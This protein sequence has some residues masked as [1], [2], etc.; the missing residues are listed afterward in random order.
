M[1]KQKTD[2]KYWE[3]W[4]YNQ[5]GADK[6]VEYD[7]AWNRH[8]SM[9]DQT[10]P[11]SPPHRQHRQGRQD[12]RRSASPGQ[13]RIEVTSR[14][15]RSPIHERLEGLQTFELPKGSIKTEVDDAAI[16]AWLPTFQPSLVKNT[17]NLKKEEDEERGVS[18]KVQP[19]YRR[20][21]NDRR[22]GRR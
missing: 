19:F 10:Y 8:R 16:G 11:P 21:P 2:P 3:K 7:P 18:N 1:R 17:V 15:Q 14:R 13:R 6:S 9:P 22:G 4:N 12:R 5:T 20:D